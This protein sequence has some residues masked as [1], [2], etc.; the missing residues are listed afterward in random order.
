MELCFGAT[1]LLRGLL[2]EKAERSELALVVNCLFDT[3]RTEGTDQ[4]VLEVLYAYVESKRFHVTAG[5]V[6]AQA[7][8]LETAPKVALLGGVA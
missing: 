4:L 8:A 3:A 2:L 6:G 5:Q 7:G 1:A